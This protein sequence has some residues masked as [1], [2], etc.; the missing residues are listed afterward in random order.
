ME[1]DARLMPAL[2]IRQPWAWLIV[3]GFK[4]IENR[5]W[6]TQFRG[7]VLIH[8]GKTLTRDYYDEQ[9]SAIARAGLMPP[10][11][12]PFDELPRGGVVGQAR[13]VDC[14]SE[15]SSPWFIAGGYGFVIRDAMPLPFMPERGKLGFFD[16]RVAREVA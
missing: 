3:H 4:D 1:S 12:P 15:S 13:I 10:G 2:S 6:P 8:A 9:A 5:G 11:F 7:A 16:V 14:V